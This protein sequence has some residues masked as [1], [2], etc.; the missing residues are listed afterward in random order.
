VSKAEIV[1]EIVTL[2]QGTPVGDF[3]RHNFTVDGNQ[4]VVRCAQ[5]AR[6][7]TS[8]GQMCKRAVATALQRYSY[9]FTAQQLP[10]LADLYATTL[11]LL[12]PSAVLSVRDTM[13][14]PASDDAQWDQAA[15]AAVCERLSR[16][17]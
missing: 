13:C 14:D 7:D 5:E 3:A 16:G 17:S 8:S 10:V 1:L 9:R 6:L 4:V 15:A 11:E 12:E 2:L